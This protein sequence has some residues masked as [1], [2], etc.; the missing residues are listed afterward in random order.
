MIK[1]GTLSDPREGYNYAKRLVKISSWIS[2]ARTRELPEL[3]WKLSA[4]A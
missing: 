2:P 4:V 1:R 3:P